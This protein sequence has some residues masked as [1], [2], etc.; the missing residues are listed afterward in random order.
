LITGIHP[1]DNL[2]DAIIEAGSGENVLKMQ[3]ENPA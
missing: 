2:P 3:I 1:F